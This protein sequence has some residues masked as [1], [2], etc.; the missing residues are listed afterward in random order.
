MPELDMVAA[1]VVYRRTRCN[2]ER[3]FVATSGHS[4]TLASSTSSSKSKTPTVQHR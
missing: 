2:W 4:V 3:S 1:C